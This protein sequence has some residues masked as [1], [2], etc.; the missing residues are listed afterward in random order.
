MRESIYHS[1]KTGS[2]AFYSDLMKDSYYKATFDLQQQT[3]LAYGFSGL[4]ENEIKHLQSFS[5]VGDGSTYST[6]IWKNTGKFNESLPE[7]TIKAT[8]Q[9]ILFR[10][11]DDELKIT[12]ITVDIGSLCWAWF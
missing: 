5:W 1:E 6:D 4:P 10:G 12:S 8:G 9:K 7:I 2:D 11:L 3:G